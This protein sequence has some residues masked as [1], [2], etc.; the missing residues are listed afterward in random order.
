MFDALG[1]TY[2]PPELRNTFE[3]WSVSAEEIKQAGLL[4]ASQARQCQ[5]VQPA[6]PSEHMQCGSSYGSGAGVEIERQAYVAKVSQRGREKEQPGLP[7]PISQG[8]QNEQGRDPQDLSQGPQ[9]L[10]RTRDDQ[11]Q[12]DGHH[13]RH[14]HSDR[15]RHELRAGEDR[16]RA[17]HAASITRDL[18]EAEMVK[19]EEFCKTFDDP[20]RPEAPGSGSSKL[21][22]R[23]REQ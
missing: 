2:V 18:E 10:S 13:G 7:L 5:L 19:L 6:P 17:V 21:G 1:L 8:V 3:N 12:H 20:T 16:L 15:L 4:A 23:S 22:S 9:K 14:G 11:H